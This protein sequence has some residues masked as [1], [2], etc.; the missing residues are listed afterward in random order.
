ME[1]VALLYSG[2]KDS[3]QALAALRKDHTREVVALVATLIDAENRLATH[4]VRRELVEAQA[5]S[6]KCRLDVVHV[7]RDASNATY[8]EKMNRTLTQ[9]RN[10]GIETIATGDLHLEEIRTYRE[11]W[12]NTL[13][14]RAHFPL[15]GR[16]PALLAEEFIDAG[17]R[18]TV[19]CVDRARM[20]IESA[21]KAFDHDWLGALPS[22]VDPNGEGGEFHTFVLDGPDFAFPMPIANQTLYSDERFAFADLQLG[23]HSTCA[24][25]GAP[26][27]CGAALPAAHCWC[28]AEP[29]ITPD[30]SATKC[31]C[32]RCLAL[33]QPAQLHHHNT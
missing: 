26:F 19:T 11:K 2:G 8:E 25:C 4:R 17:Y 9:L 23:P 16:A 29:K 22:G 32:P 1:K 7:P 28:M 3:V 33:Q 14:M 12:L 21:G 13:G 5:A 31:W 27:A 18:A 15:W 24:A 20:P 30:V 10:E 6:L